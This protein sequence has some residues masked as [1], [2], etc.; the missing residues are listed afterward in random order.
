MCA[1]AFPHADVHTQIHPSIRSTPHTSS[2]VN[3]H[4][5][6]CVE[7]HVPTLLALERISAAGDAACCNR[8][9]QHCSPSL[10]LH[11]RTQCQYICVPAH[12][13]A[14]SVVPYC[15]CV[16]SYCVLQPP[17]LQQFFFGARPAAL[18][19]LWGV[20]PPCP[21]TSQA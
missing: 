21:A 19:F 15:S 13:T 3:G 20:P 12:G 17:A 9:C 10:V 7:P 4:G 8:M 18:S 16:V 11:Y 2:G 1:S 5:V 6:V 14:S